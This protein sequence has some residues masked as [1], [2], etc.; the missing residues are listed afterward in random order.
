MG[1]P[2]LVLWSTLN[3]LDAFGACYLDKGKIGSS[4]VILKKYNGPPVD[5]PRLVS[6]AEADT[7]IATHGLKLLEDWHCNDELGSPGNSGLNSPIFNSAEF[8]KKQQAV[9]L[10]NDP[11]TAVALP[12]EN[13]SETDSL[14]I[15]AKE[16]SATSLSSP[17]QVNSELAT[18][19]DGEISAGSSTNDSLT[20]ESAA[21]RRKPHDQ[22]KETSAND[23]TAVVAPPTKKMRGK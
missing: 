13:E 4:L 12:F 2:A 7:F 10:D 18:Q 9:L 23:L 3:Q 5:P 14:A 11:T 1:V 19:I 6:P 21:P 8:L 15:L 16:P 20:Q 17:V 22:A